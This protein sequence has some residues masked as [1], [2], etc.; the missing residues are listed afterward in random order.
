MS[1]Q[2][3][4]VKSGSSLKSC[5]T[6]CCHLVNMWEQQNSLKQSEKFRSRYENTTCCNFFQ[7]FHEYSLV[8]K[9]R[10]TELL[11]NNWVS[12]CQR[13]STGLTRCQWQSTGS[14]TDVRRRWRRWH[15][16]T[17]L[18]SWTR[19][20]VPTTT[21]NVWYTSHADHLARL[22][23]DWLTDEREARRCQRGLVSLH[24]TNATTSDSAQNNITTGS[25]ICQ[26]A[27]IK[28]LFRKIAN[29]LSE[30]IEAKDLKLQKNITITVKYMQ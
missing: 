3:T 21:H 20:A 16:G 12:W 8:N 18:W 14:I 5:S 1:D 27:Y 29:S 6:Q 7:N 25:S 2:Q 24:C 15:T 30:V 23:V 22:T 17:R 13:L 28:T 4:T 10:G 26:T 11:T 19:L 9:K